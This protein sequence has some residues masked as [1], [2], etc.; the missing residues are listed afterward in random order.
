MERIIRSYEIV[1]EE[2][3]DGFKSFGL[4]TSLKMELPN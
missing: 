1:T 2:F 4:N 3:N